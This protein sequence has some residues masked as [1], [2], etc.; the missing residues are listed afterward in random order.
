MMHTF[1]DEL[2]SSLSEVLATHMALHFPRSRWGDLERMARS[3]AREAGAADPQAF[4]QRLLASPWTG[5]QLETL[6]SHFTINESYLWREPQAFEALATQMLPALIHAREN[7]SR[8]LRMWSAGCSTGEEPYSMAIALKRMLPA[9]HDWNITI[10]ATD[11]NPRAMSKARAGVYGEWSFRNAPPWLT[12]GYFRMK[13]DGKWEIAPEI[14]KMV[15]F[16]SL[17]LAEDSYPSPL[18]NTNAMDVIFCRNVLMYF[19]PERAQTVGQHLYESLMDDGWLIVSA[20]ELSQRYFSQ[21]ASV[22]FPGTMVYRKGAGNPQPMRA[23]SPA[24]P[25][26]R[27]AFV[28]PSVSLGADVAR[29]APLIE[30][31]PRKLMPLTA[32]PVDA[33]L[34]K[35][36]HDA[37][38][39]LGLTIRAL[40]NQGRL[41]E[42]LTVCDAALA[43]DKLAAGLYYLRAT[44]L[45]E[46]QCEGEAKSALQRAL[47]IAPDFVLAHFALGNLAIR[48]GD[49]QTARRYFKNAQ[50]LLSTCREED[51]LPEAEGL[52]AGRFLEIIRATMQMGAGA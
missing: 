7:G 5:E 26:T 45:Q 24:T 21:F 9:L 19:T 38:R 18:N 30:L 44:I 49:V 39:A 1:S 4:I 42:A 3:T 11:I 37:P 34:E 46:L 29:L 43:A 25:V 17:N 15:T 14:G 52:T 31:S 51:I 12:E 6:A 27:E 8:R 36:D 33:R 20:A 13:T 32:R 47:Y 41:A 10:L 2:L 50:S 23:P 35:V 22:H 28:Q 48:R 16:S 40:A